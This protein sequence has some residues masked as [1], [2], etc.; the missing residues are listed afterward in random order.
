MDKAKTEEKTITAGPELVADVED[1][2]TEKVAVTDRNLELEQA[3]QNYV[4]D[5]KEEKRLVRKLDMYMMPTLWF[6]YILAYIDRQNI[7]RTVSAEQ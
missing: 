3:L 7:V 4:P 5:S 1:G 2:Y 6:M